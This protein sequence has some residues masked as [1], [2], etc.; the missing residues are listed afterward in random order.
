MLNYLL[1]LVNIKIEKSVK[2]SLKV[3]TLE[4]IT[5][6]H[7]LLRKHFVDARISEIKAKQFSEQMFYV[8][9]NTVHNGHTS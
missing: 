2:K 5:V 3:K 7:I 6:P 8:R 1:Y 4:K 9:I